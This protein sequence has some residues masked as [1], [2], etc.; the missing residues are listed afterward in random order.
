LAQQPVRLYVT[1]VALATLVVFTGTLS[2]TMTTHS[3][4][5]EAAAPTVPMATAAPKPV[6]AKPVTKPPQAPP[7]APPVQHFTVQQGD[8]LWEIASHYGVTMAQLLAANPEVDNP[9]HLQ[10]GQQLRLP[11]AASNTAAA[12]SALDDVALRGVF[13]WPVRAPI[14]SVFGPRDGRNHAGID[15]AANMGD[16]IRAARDG[17]VIYSGEISGY[18][19]TVIL[20]HADGTRTLY[21]HSS[22]RLVSNGDKVRQGQTIA[23]VGS[24]GHSTGPHLHFEV[25]VNDRPRDPLLYLPKR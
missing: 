6:A 25:I 11:G 24:T 18:G 21:A 14:S 4:S 12:A 1:G 23:L 22:K 20:R 17:E 5:A 13:A 2:Y 16:S 10:I 19:E 7:P 8:T 15:L 3:R 9:G